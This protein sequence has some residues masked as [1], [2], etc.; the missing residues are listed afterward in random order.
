MRRCFRRDGTTVCI[1]G[2]QEICDFVTESI[3]TFAADRDEPSSTRRLT[4]DALRRL[5]RYSHRDDCDA[6]RLKIWVKLLPGDGLSHM[7]RRAKTVIPRLF[8]GESLDKGF[9]EW[10]QTAEPKDLVKAIRV[11]S[12][13]G[14]V[15]VSGRRCV[16]GKQSRTRLEPL[17]FGHAR[18]AG[19]S[20]L[21]GGRPKHGAQDRL[22]LNLSLDWLEATGQAPT[23]G[24][25]DHTGF[26]D[27]V[28]TVFESMGERGATQ[29]LRRY[30]AARQTMQAAKTKP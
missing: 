26:G 19:G 6:R 20:K 1:S 22:V 3:S 2:Q 21:L 25:S 16:S 9:L 29:A 27:L 12:A 10:A 24:R 13:E 5:W 14:A 4:H 17:V 28:H 18:G 23:G 30:W 8:P 15:R 7:E 11:L